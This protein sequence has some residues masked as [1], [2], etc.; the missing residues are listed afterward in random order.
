MTPKSRRRGRQHTDAAHRR[1]VLLDGAIDGGERDGAVAN[2]LQASMGT[3]VGTGT[4]PNSQED[5]AFGG[6]EAAPA[7]SSVPERAGCGS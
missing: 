4:V 3:A 2:E 1:G 5:H 6:Q 7:S